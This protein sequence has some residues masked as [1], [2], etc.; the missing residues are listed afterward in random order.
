MLYIYLATSNRVIS[1]V[2]IG[3]KG[4]S[5]KPIYFTGQTLQREET[6]YKKLE[7]KIALALVLAARKLNPYF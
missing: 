6:R 7:K 4:K 5:Q 3:E 1:L 2:L